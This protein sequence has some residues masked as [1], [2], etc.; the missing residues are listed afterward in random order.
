MAFP[1]QCFCRGWQDFILRAFVFTSATSAKTSTRSKLVRLLPLLH[2]ST[3]IRSIMCTIIVVQ[4]LLYKYC[5]MQCNVLFS[6]IKNCVLKIISDA[7][8]EFK[9]KNKYERKMLNRLRI[10]KRKICI[11]SL[12]LMLQVLFFFGASRWTNGKGRKQKSYSKM[13]HYRISLI[14]WC[15]SKACSIVTWMKR[16]RM[17]KLLKIY[18]W[19]DFL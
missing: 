4:I 2:I 11:N 3:R 19:S 9:N 5:H 6:R 15:E 14:Q 8:F 10:F 1:Q 13:W 17:N 16:K 18:N 7:L 12:C